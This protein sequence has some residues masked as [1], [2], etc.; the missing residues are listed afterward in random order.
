MLRR[1]EYIETVF[2]VRREIIELH[3]TTI[4]RMLC[5]LS[6]I[7][8]MR[9]TVEHISSSTEFFH[10]MIFESQFGISSCLQERTETDRLPVYLR[11]FRISISVM[12]IRR[13]MTVL[14]EDI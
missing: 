7:R 6:H 3:T 13:P 8:F 5:L 9:R 11:Y 14:T 4:D 10:V 1:C 2:L 12:V